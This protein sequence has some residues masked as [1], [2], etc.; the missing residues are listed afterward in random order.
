MVSLLHAAM[1]GYLSEEQKEQ[2]KKFTIL[3][4]QPFDP[5][6]KKTVAKLQSP[7]GEIFHATK[8]APQVILN[9]SENKKKIGER[10]MNDI[11]RL[12]K[13]GYR[14][15]GVAISDEQGMKLSSVRP[16]V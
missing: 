8:G 3:H 14:T 6:G 5:V 9:L 2:R 7:D 13:S 12:G 1:V 10:V 16:I 4:F 11:E 15:L